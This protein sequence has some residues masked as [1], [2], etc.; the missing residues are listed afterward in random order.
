LTRVDG[1]ILRLDVEVFSRDAN[2]RQTLGAAFAAAGF[3]TATPSRS[4]HA[5]LASELPASDQEH[6]DALSANTR[7][8]IRAVNKHPLLLRPVVD[9][10]F[11][12]RMDA[13]MRETMQRTGGFYES[14]DWGWRIALSQAAPELSRLIGLFRAE[15]DG[16]ESLLAFAWGCCHGDHAHYEASGSTRPDDLKVSLSYALMWDLICWA[17][18]NRVGWFD[19][20][21]V[22]VESTGSS[23]PVEGIADF[24]RHFGD[25]VLKVGERWI[26]EPSALRS[27]MARSVGALAKFARRLRP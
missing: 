8:H 19:L 9:Y 3:A 14:Q 22:P 4:Y 1:R 20:G 7:R 10:A 16:P 2:R 24:K 18:R 5:T 21:G 23:S 13:L 17:R 26:L 11:A 12:G 15:T 25:T 27:K 6:L